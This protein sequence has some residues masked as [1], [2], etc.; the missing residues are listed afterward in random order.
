MEVLLMTVH[1]IGIASST[2]QLRS[3]LEDSITNPLPS[4]NKGK[5]IN[6]KNTHS[7]SSRASTRSVGTDP[8]YPSHG[9]KKS[10]SSAVQIPSY[11]TSSF[12]G[13]RRFIKDSTPQYYY[14]ASA[15]VSRATN[16]SNRV[17]SFSCSSP[18]AQH[19]T[20]NIHH[21]TGPQRSARYVIVHPHS[22]SSSDASCSGYMSRRAPSHNMSLHVPVSNN[23]SYSSSSSDES[24]SD[25]SSSS[26]SSYTSSSSSDVSSSSSLSTKGKSGKTN[27]EQ[28]VIIVRESDTQTPLG[29]STG[30][31]GTGKNSAYKR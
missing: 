2:R 28:T 19:I 23:H 8:L 29:A 31:K 15:V 9:T 21:H 18:R 20:Y 25:T 6:S 4:Y 14:P 3:N 10:S 16:G 11:N 27:R 12:V 7:T 22:Y 5:E 30:A 1:Y 26:S 24:Y 17:S 13:A